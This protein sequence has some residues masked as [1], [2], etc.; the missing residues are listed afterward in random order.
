MQT[1]KS[2]SN[3]RPQE[4]DITSSGT[5]VYHNYNVIEVEKEGVISYEYDVDKMTHQE[6]NIQLQYQIDKQKE[7]IDQLLALSSGV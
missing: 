4:W 2:Q 1:I 6:Y 7:V 3:E 5:M